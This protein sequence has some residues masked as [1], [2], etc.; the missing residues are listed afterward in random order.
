MRDRRNTLR[1][2]LVILAAALLAGPAAASPRAGGVP[3]QIIFPVVGPYRYTND[4]GDPRPQG[5]HEGNDILAP[6]H[7]PV[8]AVE[9]GK[10]KFWTTSSRAGCMLYLYGASGTTYLY[11]HLNNDLTMANDNRGKCVAG[12]SYWPGLKDGAKVVAG[13][14][15]GFVGDSGDADGTPHLHFEVH[16]HDGGPT[17]PFPYLNKATRILFTAPPGSAVTL[18]LKGTIVAATDTQLTMKVQTAMV[19]PSRLKL[20]GLRKP[21][22][23]TLTPTALVDVPGTPSGSVA[24]RSGSLVGKPAII[25]TLP[26]RT[27]LLTQ[28]ARDGAFSAARVVLGA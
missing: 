19:F 16:P 4:F 27:T 26:A 3:S 17:N 22:M 6:K 21:M 11:I 5:R 7:S 1:G 8:V 10:I 24:D 28:A 25:L 23:L 2:V 15:I 9:D 12:G 20:L 18:S 13:Q 14:A